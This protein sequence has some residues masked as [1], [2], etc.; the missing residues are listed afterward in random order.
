MIVIL[1]KF[2]VELKDKVAIGDFVYF[3]IKNTPNGLNGYQVNKIDEKN[4]GI[5]EH[6]TTTYVNKT[7]NIKINLL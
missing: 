2:H 6:R 5:V 1:Q 4:T 3:D 7:V